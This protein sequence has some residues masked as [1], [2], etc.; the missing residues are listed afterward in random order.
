M[1][2]AETEIVVDRFAVKGRLLFE[3]KGLMRKPRQIRRDFSDLLVLF[4]QA[5][6]NWYARFIR[7]W[8]S[9]LG[10]LGA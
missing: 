8:L 6:H 10:G 5:G 3:N 7:S 2:V 9:E 4:Y 1:Y